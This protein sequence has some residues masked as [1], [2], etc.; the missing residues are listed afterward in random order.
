M[1]PN[2]AEEQESIHAGAFGGGAG[3]GRSIPRGVAHGAR[4]GFL[5]ERSGGTCLDGND[6][7]YLRALAFGKNFQLSAKI[8][9]AF[10]HPRSPTPRAKPEAMSASSSAL[11]PRPSSSTSRTMWP[12]ACARRMDAV[13]LSECR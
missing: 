9:D 1:G 4:R 3:D 2:G 12:S 10:A 7:L 13:A 6:G 8:L 11:M 5:R